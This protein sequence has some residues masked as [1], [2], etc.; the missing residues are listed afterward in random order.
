MIESIFLKLFIRFLSEINFST[1]GSIRKVVYR[2]T[3]KELLLQQ[4][5]KIL[6]PKILSPLFDFFEDFIKLI[7]IAI[8]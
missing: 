2:T 6:I 1:L 7:V 4:N 3:Q 8:V 5:T